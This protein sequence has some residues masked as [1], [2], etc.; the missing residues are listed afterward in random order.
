MDICEAAFSMGRKRAVAWIDQATSHTAT[1][2]GKSQAEATGGGS[3]PGQGDAAVR[4]A[5][6]NADQFSM[7][8]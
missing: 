6:K 3:G 8:R 4:P 1:Q 2:R 7:N 5:K